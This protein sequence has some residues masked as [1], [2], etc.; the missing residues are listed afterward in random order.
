[1]NPMKSHPMS[2]DRMIF[3]VNASVFA[4]SLYMLLC[5]HLDEGEKPTLNLARRAWNSTEEK[6]AEAA[7]E[8]VDLNILEPMDP[9]EFDLPISINPREKWFWTRHPHIGNNLVRH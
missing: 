2:M 1:M 6:L 9:L 4:T 8:L 7:R 3:E 5:S